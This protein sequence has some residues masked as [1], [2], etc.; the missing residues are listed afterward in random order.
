[1]TESNEARGGTTRRIY[2]ALKAQ[3]LGGTYGPEDRLPSTRALAAELGVSRTTVT[4]AYEQLLSEG[5]LES[6]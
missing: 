3:I 5:F 1:M 4:A 6:R 2:E